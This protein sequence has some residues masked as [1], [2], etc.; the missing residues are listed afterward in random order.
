[1]NQLMGLFRHN[2]AAKIIA[3]LAAVILWFFVMNEQNPFLENTISVPVVT[4]N[5]A[6]NMVVTTKEETV[7]FRLRGHRS[8]FLAAPSSEFKAVLDLAGIN[9]GTYDIKAEEILPPGLELIS[10][11]PDKIEVK[12]ERI[13]QRQVPVM[14]QTT[15]ILA[16]GYTLVSMIPS[17]KMITVEGTREAVE[18]VTR[19]V[20]I[21][22]LSENSKDFAVEITLQPF[23][24]KGRPAEGVIV[25]EGRINVEV[26]IDKGQTKKTVVVQPKFSGEPANGYVVGKVRVVPA[27]V[28]ISGSASVVAAI[29]EVD[30]LPVSVSDANTSFSRLVRVKLPGGTSALPNEVMVYADI[31]EKKQTD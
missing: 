25:K 10:M 16:E 15:G 26:D 31:A 27:T 28:E 17:L 5:V 11:T 14:I 13:I 19:A 8:A 1:M 6:D 30:T 29:T 24:E 7:K 4:E 23:N 21:V 22:T 18:K 3:V 2:I 12:V 9:E 20:G